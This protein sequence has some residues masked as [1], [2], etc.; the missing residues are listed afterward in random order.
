MT[1]IKAIRKDIIARNNQIKCELDKA[2]Q[3]ISKYKQLLFAQADLTGMAIAYNKKE[4][5]KSQGG[6]G[7]IYFG[8]L[9]QCFALVYELRAELKSNLDFLRGKNNN[10]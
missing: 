9:S 7:G 2:F 6:I 8:K 5:V 4:V 10:A 1:D 3:Q